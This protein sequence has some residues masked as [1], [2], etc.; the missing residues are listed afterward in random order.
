MGDNGLRRRPTNLSRHSAVARRGT[1]C[2]QIALAFEPYL[3]QLRGRQSQCD[4]GSLKSI[5]RAVP[6]P[7]Q[8]PVLIQISFIMGDNGLRRRPTNLSRHSAVAR[9]GTRC[10][11]IALAFEPYSSQL[12]GLANASERWLLSSSLSKPTTR[13][14]RPG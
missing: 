1:R 9:R 2:E 5:G 3:S 4:G 6:L 7:T 11:Q 10:E 14:N 12:R 8:I 13:L